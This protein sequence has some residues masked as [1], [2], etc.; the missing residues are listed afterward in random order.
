MQERIMCNVESTLVSI[1]SVLNE[2]GK[3]LFIKY[4]TLN[5]GLFDH[6]YPCHALSQILDA[7]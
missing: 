6:P 2:A 4:V 5:W 3:G 1:E 7:P